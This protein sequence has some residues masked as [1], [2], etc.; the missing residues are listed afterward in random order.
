MAYKRHKLRN[1]K[2]RSELPSAG[3]IF[4]RCTRACIEYARL[5]DCTGVF[6]LGGV[7]VSTGRSQL[8]N[9]DE[10]VLAKMRALQ[11][12]GVRDDTRL[13]QAITEDLRANRNLTNVA[14]GYWV[15]SVEPEAAEHLETRAMPYES[16]ATALL[17]SDGFYRAVDTFQL[18][19]EDRLIARAKDE[20]LTSILA[21]V[22]RIENGDPECVQY[23]DLNRK[24][25]RQH[26]CLRRSVQCHLRR[27]AWCTRQIVR[28]ISVAQRNFCPLSIEIRPS[29]GE[30]VPRA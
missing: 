7:T 5:G 4:V 21:E 24:T 8:H 26:F 23:P 27:I 16:Q 2:V 9:L 18:V 13:R 25:I 12:T 20:G 15:L 6:A 19:G 3:I 11:R 30:L 14:G 29:E 17:M 10:Q 22:R 28:S 1:T